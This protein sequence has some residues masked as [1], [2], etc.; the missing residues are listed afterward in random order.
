LELVIKLLT[1]EKVF[2]NV[3]GTANIWILG[4]ELYDADF[5]QKI[6]FKE[7]LQKKM[8]E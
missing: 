4:I 3:T 7:Y 8:E 2:V 6:D 1:K 5:S